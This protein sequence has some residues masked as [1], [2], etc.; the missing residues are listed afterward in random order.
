MGRG[1]KQDFSKEDI[2][3]ANE[4]L[5]ILSTSLIIWQMQIKPKMSYHFT[6]VRMAIIKMS[7]SNKCWRGCGEKANPVHCQWNCKLVQPQWKMVW[8]LLK[9]LKLEL[10]YDPTIPLLRIYPQEM[11]TPNQ[12]VRCTP[13]FV[14]AL[15]TIAKAW[16][17]Q[18]V[19]SR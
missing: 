7:T 19:I 9:K 8:R 6:S 12:K 18:V 4:H 14:I 2:Q 10:L 1:Y 3:M 17:L 13:R 5:Q 11:K 15:F 16:K